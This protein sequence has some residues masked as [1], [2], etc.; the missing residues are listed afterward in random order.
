LA[1]VN[2]EKKT[3][4]LNSQISFE[5][6]LF[7]TRRV[8][9]QS[10]LLFISDLAA[11]IQAAEGSILLNR[12]LLEEH[13]RQDPAFVCALSPLDSEEHD[14]RIVRLASEAASAA[15]VGPFA[16]VPGALADL[17][18]EAMLSC[19]ASV[20]LVE[21]G[22]EIAANSEIPLN[23]GVHAGPSPVSAR[24]GFRLESK[25][26]PV[27]VSTSSASVSHALTFGEADAAVAVADTAALSDAS[28]TAICNAVKGTDIEASVQAGLETA[29]KIRGL[30][31]ALVVRGRYVGSIGRLPRL[32][33]LKGDIEGMLKAGLYDAERQD[34]V[35]L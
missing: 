34:A 3:M 23:V 6:G 2:P 24:I 22:G 11:A 32:L 4:T 30:R 12:A 13:I 27:G 15:N 35:F 26:C 20:A 18:M 9:K 1:H 28:A 8:I 31:G 25:D 10:N 21:N 14:A 33:N 17:A 29:E 7:R 19:G 5:R 16:A